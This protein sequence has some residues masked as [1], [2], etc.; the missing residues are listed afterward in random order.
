MSSPALKLPVMA[1]LALARVVLSRSDKVRPPSTR[2][3]MDAALSPAMKAV[4]PPPT[5]TTGVCAVAATLTARCAGALFFVPSLT[6]KLT[7]RTA[8]SGVMALLLYVTARR[9]ACHCATVA[10]APED[11]RVSTPVPLL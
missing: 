7:A 8:V 5:V 9:A 4:L 2:T 10:V 11:A 3:G 1:T 6:T